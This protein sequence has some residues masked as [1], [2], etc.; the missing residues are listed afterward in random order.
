MNGERDGIIA[1]GGSCVKSIL[2]LPP[3]NR[4][5]MKQKGNSQIECQG[6]KKELLLEKQQQC[7][8]IW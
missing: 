8:H 1:G 4:L 5:W 7:F 3:E 2:P 6:S